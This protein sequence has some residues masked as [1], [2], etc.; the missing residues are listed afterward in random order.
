MSENSGVR[1]RWVFGL[2]A[3]ALAIALALVLDI[4]GKLLKAPS[5]PGGPDDTIV[6][7]C[8]SSCEADGSSASFCD[9]YCA[10]V[11][12]GLNEGRSRRDFSRFLLAMAKDPS[13]EEFRELKSTTEACAELARS[14][15]SDDP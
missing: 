13:S 3:F 8:S 2:A 14:R 7:G 11:L 1:N 6:S 9:S 12:E 4:P 15:S 10:C 5:E